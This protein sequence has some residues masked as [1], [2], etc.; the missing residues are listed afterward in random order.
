[1]HVQYE[2]RHL[3]RHGGGLLDRDELLDLFQP[4][5]LLLV[6]L[7]LHRHAD[8]LRG[9]R[10]RDGLRSHV[11][12]LV[13]EHVLHGDAH[14]LFRD[15]GSGRLQHLERPVRV[16]L[17]DHVLHGHPHVLLQDHLVHRV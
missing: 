16:L 15:H 17:V 9:Y 2:L 11:R 1:L 5:R 12:L 14:A 8:A 10:I 4:T 6:E 3:L 13:V 7:S